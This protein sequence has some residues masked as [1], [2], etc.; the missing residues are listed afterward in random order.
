LIADRRNSEN[1]APAFE[2]DRPERMAGQHSS[3]LKFFETAA[4]Q[5]MLFQLLA[6]A[7]VLFS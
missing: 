5:R 1:R 3:I 7:L 4:A 6:H 2:G